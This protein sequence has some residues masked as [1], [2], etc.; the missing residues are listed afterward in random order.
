MMIIKKLDEPLLLTK[1]KIVKY[2][3]WMELLPNLQNML[4]F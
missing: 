1:K 2:L 4:F 3:E